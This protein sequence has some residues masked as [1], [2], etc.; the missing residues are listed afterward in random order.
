MINAVPDAFPLRI[1]LAR[2]SFSGSS[3]WTVT[4]TFGATLAAYECCVTQ[5]ALSA[6]LTAEKRDLNDI[7][8]KADSGGHP[9]LS[10]ADRFGFKCCQIVR[11]G[12]NLT[13]GIRKSL[14]I[15]IRHS[16]RPFF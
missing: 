15:L 11:K 12:K 7:L 5:D 8:K 2:P 4:K 14:G 10:R 6:A 16:R 3:A 9:P 1:N 13:A